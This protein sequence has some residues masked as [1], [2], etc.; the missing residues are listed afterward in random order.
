M[1]D[2]LRMV[3]TIVGVGVVV[4]ALVVVV[5]AVAILVTSRRTD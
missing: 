3:F 4:G 5:G 1:T 2:R